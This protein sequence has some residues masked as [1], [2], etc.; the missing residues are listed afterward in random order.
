MLATIHIDAQR[1]VN[2][3][4]CRCPSC[5]VAVSLIIATFRNIHCS[6]G[7]ETRRKV[8]LGRFRTCL[9]RGGFKG[10]GGRDEVGFPCGARSLPV[11][12]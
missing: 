12:A 7:F 2:A 4:S 6:G 10:R 11:H 9:C 5:L 1:V 3:G 8:L